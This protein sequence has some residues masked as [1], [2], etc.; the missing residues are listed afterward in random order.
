MQALNSHLATSGHAKA[1]Q[2][3]S[4][5]RPVMIPV[6]Q[7]IDR[8]YDVTKAPTA[9]LGAQGDWW[10]EFE[11]FQ[12]IK[13]F[14]SRNGY[15]L[16]Y[17]ARLFAAILYEWSEVNGFVACRTIA[18]LAAWKGRGKQVRSSGKDAR[19]LKRMTPMQ[20]VLEV[21]QLY[22]PGLGG[23]TTLSREALQ[24]QSFGAL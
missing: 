23:T 13:H 14:A 6:G 20:S 10:L 8:F 2:G 11:H 24:V 18:P 3:M 19:D 5:V 21:Y 15:T 9:A 12:T 16:S 17:A 4:M 22:V 7:V 1:M